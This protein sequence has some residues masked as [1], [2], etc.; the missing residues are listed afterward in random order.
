MVVVGHRR[1]AEGSALVFV[2]VEKFN[3]GVSSEV[4]KRKWAEI[5]DQVN[6]L[7]ENH[8][9]VLTTHSVP[10]HPGLVVLK[11]IGGEGLPQGVATIW[12]GRGYHGEGQQTDQSTPTIHVVHPKNVI[13][14]ECGTLTQLLFPPDA[15]DHE[16]MG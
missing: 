12:G 3:H 7:G 5:T 9:E 4:K 15:S 2:S 1:R 13:E 6:A 16:E 11:V 14:D 10:S 8:R